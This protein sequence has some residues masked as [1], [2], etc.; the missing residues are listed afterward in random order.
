MRPD[1]TLSLCRQSHGR[2][3]RAIGELADDDF[4]L[5][6]RLPRWS[7]AHVIAHVLNKANAHVWVFGGP[8][9]D[10][11]RRVYP[12]GYDADVT[13]DAGASRPPAELRS[14]LADAFERLEHAWDALDEELWDRK[15]VMTGGPRT[16]TEIVS[17]HLRNIE[18]HHV[19]LDIGYR[20]SDWPSGFVEAELEKRLAG[21]ADRAPHHDLLAW[22]MGRAPAP[23]LGPW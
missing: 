9:E 3:L 14:A 7:R 16:M 21:L 18:V 8:A 22:L 17:H 10:E 13:A 4:H 2:L 11:V 6:S 15:A 5:P 20:P 1:P 23:E 19:D 12:P